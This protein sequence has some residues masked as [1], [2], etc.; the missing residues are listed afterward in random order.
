VFC[1]DLNTSSHAIFPQDKSASCCHSPSRRLGF[2][3]RQAQHLAERASTAA[4]IGPI[5]IATYAPARSHGMKF[6]MAKPDKL[7]WAEDCPEVGF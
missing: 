4:S 7:R 1:A 5:G 2:E 3:S 6:A